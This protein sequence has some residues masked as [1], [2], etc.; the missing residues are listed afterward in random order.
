MKNA[1]KSLIEISKL[2][3][4]PRTGLVWLGIKKPVTIAEHIFQT[5]ILAWLLTRK[6]N[7][8]IG[9][10][11]KIALSHDLCEVY[12]GDMTPFQGLLPRN[13]EKRKEVLKRW[14]R[15]P[16]KEKEDRKRKRFETEKNCFLKL[17]NP[18]KPELKREIFA[19]W[20]DYEKRVSPE[21]K[22][23]KQV[24]Q[25]AGMIE[26][27]ESLGIKRQKWVTPWWEEAEEAI[28]DPL[29]Q[30][31]LKIIQKNFYGQVPKGYKKNKELENILDFLL[32]IGKLKRV[33]R[34][35]WTIRGIKK[36]ET[37]AGHIFTL[38]LMAW[39]FGREKEELNMEKLLKMALCHE[40]SAAY[41]G[42]TTPYDRILP[43]NKK[44]RGEILKKMLRLSKREKE[45]TFLKDY[46]KEKKALGKLT[47][48]LKPSLK[49]EI[50]QLWKEY[51]M[52]SGP[53][54]HFLSQLNV[55]AI[56]LQGLLYEKKYKNF[57]A[58]PIWEWAFEIC[59][60]PICLNLLEEM[61]KKFYKSA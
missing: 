54:G 44:E 7:L 25:I 40:L 22:F 27:L 50:V 5:A 38:A 56:L 57:S 49:K 36:P 43:E 24:D 26:A 13:K 52:K 41:T 61:K 58:T 37:V 6:K 55:L 18:L 28:D 10:M 4:M 60:D 12:A 51:R 47:F 8:N 34:L 59:D 33:P 1:L 32:E 20:I 23:C 3:E 19:S 15:T 9:R 46:Q 35:Y 16:L 53:E 2:K 21:G 31:F 48:K 42:D 30:K 17:V 14:I 11:I 29:L 45:W 39:V